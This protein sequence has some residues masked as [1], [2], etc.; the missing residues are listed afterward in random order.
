MEN[1]KLT[2]EKIAAL[3]DAQIKYAQALWSKQGV[4]QARTLLSNLM[5][6]DAE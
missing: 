4:N 5:L 6:T 1:A 3:K 2:R